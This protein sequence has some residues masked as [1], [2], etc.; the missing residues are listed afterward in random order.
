MSDGNKRSRATAGSHHIARGAPLRSA[1]A[2]PSAAP[3]SLAAGDDDTPGDGDGA[4]SWPVG[5]VG[6]VANRS[7][8]A[9]C[10]AIASSAAAAAERCRCWHTA[11]AMAYRDATAAS[12]CGGAAAAADDDADAAPDALGAE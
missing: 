12:A 6:T 4:S 3:F 2:P 8:S 7:G 9:D 5:P 11:S 10:E 1:A